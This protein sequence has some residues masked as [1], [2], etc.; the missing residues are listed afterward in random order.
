[1]DVGGEL[2]KLAALSL[3]KEQPIP[4]EQ[5]TGWAPQLIW[6]FWRRDKSLAAAAAARNEITIPYLSA[7]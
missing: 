1:M 5:E 7:T 3:G 4:I 6:A 2:H